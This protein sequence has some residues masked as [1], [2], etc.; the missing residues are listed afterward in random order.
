MLLRVPK[1]PDHNIREF[2]Q[3]FTREA[4]DSPGELIFVRKRDH[5][6]REGGEVGTGN[7]AGPHQIIEITCPQHLHDFREQLGLMT[8]VA[9]TQGKAQRGSADPVT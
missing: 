5:G 4:E 7:I 3:F 6:G 1:M 9:G 8:F 2:R